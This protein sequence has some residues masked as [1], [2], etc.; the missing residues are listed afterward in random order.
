MWSTRCR[1]ILLALTLLGFVT[2]ST[3]AP[4]TGE[5]RVHQRAECG[6]LFDSLEPAAFGSFDVDPEVGGPGS[7]SF[8]VSGGTLTAEWVRDNGVREVDSSTGQPVEPSPINANAFE[9][10]CALTRGFNS[11][12]PAACGLDLWNSQNP[13]MA[14]GDPISNSPT[15]AVAFASVQS[16]QGPNGASPITGGGLFFSLAGLTT[17]AQ[18]QLRSATADKPFPAGARTPLVSLVVDPNDGPAAD[19]PIGFQNLFTQFGLSRF[20]TDEQ[21]ALLGCGPFYGTNCDIDGPDLMTAEVSALLQSWPGPED[22]G[23]DSTDPGL[24]QPG[25]VGYAGEPVCTRYEASATSILPGCRGPADPGYDTDVDGSLF[26]PDGVGTSYQRV[27]PFTGQEWARETAIFSWNYLQSLVALSSAPD[28]DNVLTSQFDPDDPLRTDGCSFANPHPCCNVASTLSLTTRPLEGDSSDQPPL[29]HWLWET[30]A[31]YLVTD[32]TGELEDFLGWTLFAFGP[33]SSRESGAEIGVAFFLV[34][35][36]P[37]PSMPVSPLIVSHP[38]PDGIDGTSDDNFAGVAYGMVSTPTTTPTPTPTV[39][40]TPTP[41]ST[42]EPTATPTPAPTAM[43]TPSPAPTPTPLPVGNIPM[44]KLKRAKQMTVLV[45]PSKVQRSLDK[46]FTMGECAAA[47]NG[48]VMCRLKRGK[49][50]S[51]VVPHRKV[52]RSLDKGMTLGVCR[53]P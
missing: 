14:G 51:V 17:A 29:R 46:G 36:D 45:P 37:L 11:L 10:F 12:D 22:T 49:L 8:N 24:D 42:G 35:P 52:Q 23:W 4:I 43:P 7:V 13:A 20:L 18:D 41:T 34:P 27:H 9:G 32:A 44:C 25:T 19:H 30:G 47:T 21:E 28:P 6:G 16:G 38:G 1:S 5:L 53:A 26:G 2:A 50:T 3:A 33:E 39:T 15:I 31:E 48:V 40:P